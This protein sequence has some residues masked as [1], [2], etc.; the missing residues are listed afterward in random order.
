[1]NKSEQVFDYLKA[2]IISG[3]L[4]PGAHIKV[5]EIA[6]ILSVSKV[7]V[8]EAIKKLEASGYVEVIHNIGAKVKRFNLEELEQIVLIRQQLEPLAT[9]LAAERIDAKTIKKLQLLA[10]KMDALVQSKDKAEYSLI[11]QDFHMTLYRASDSDL[12]V[13]LIEDLWNRSERSALVFTLFPDRFANSNL[14]HKELIRYLQER[15]VDRAVE[16]IAHQKSEGFISV[17]QVLKQYEQLR[18]D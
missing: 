13:D 11:N 14:E 7:P 5:N 3:K 4:A 8:R 12:L 10:E 15:N 9:R 1:M 18:G 16:I 2:Q 6:D 17:V